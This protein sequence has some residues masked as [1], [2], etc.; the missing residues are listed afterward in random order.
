MG[1]RKPPGRHPARQRKEI[2]LPSD[3]EEVDV[4]EIPEPVLRAII[5]QTTTLI[6]PTPP[7]E[8]LRKLHDIKPEYS[9]RAFEYA[10]KEQEARHDD[11]RAGRKIE[12][13]AN[14]TLHGWGLGM[15]FFLAVALL[16]IG[17]WAMSQ[18]HE[19]IAAG[20]I[21]T[22]VLELVLVVIGNFID[23]MRRGKE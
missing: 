9:D 5:G 12:R 4:E 21:G 18:D 17:V 20:T 13:A 1:R 16:G 11:R 6:S 8:E 3:P 15:S 7:A 10:E 19:L 23:K 2:V 14:V 22:V